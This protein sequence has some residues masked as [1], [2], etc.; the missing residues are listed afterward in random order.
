VARAVATASA[1]GGNQ[2]DISG[3]V[4][5]GSGAVGG[6]FLGAGLR[7][8]NE[9]FGRAGKEV[10]FRNARIG[11]AV[12]GAEAAYRDSAARQPQTPAQR[13]VFDLLAVNAGTPSADA[14]AAALAHGAAAGS[15]LGMAARRLADALNGLMRDRGG[16]AQARQEYTE[17][18]QWR[19]AIDAFQRYVAD[20][21]ASAF[22]PP[23]P[24]LLAIHAA[25]QRVVEEALRRDAR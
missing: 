14:V 21:P 25:L 13:R 3:P 12:R 22:S 10:V 16:C 11:C 4:V 8:E 1:Q 15:P 19:E 17:A 18:P 24:E 20:A 23:A 9:M 7:S 5:T 2:S 6:S